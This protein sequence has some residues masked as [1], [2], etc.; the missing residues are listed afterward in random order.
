MKSIDNKCLKCGSEE[1]LKI[2]AVPGE[3]PHIVI[4][5]PLMRPV[6]VS[7]H[8]CTKCGF[9]EEWVEN[10]EDLSKLRDEYGR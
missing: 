9:I 3:G 1:L 5:E 8:I 6:L 4:G 7:K 10:N 2:P